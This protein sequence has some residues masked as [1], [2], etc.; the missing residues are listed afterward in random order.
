MSKPEDDPDTYDLATGPDVK[1]KGSV[2]FATTSAS[3]TSDP[4]ALQRELV[5][6][7]AQVADLLSILRRTN[8]PPSRPSV[9]GPGTGDPSPSLAIYSRPMFTTSK[10]KHLG[11]AASSLTSGSTPSTSA[12]SAGHADPDGPLARASI[13]PPRPYTSKMRFEDWWSQ[14]S[15]YLT[16]VAPANISDEA[17]ATHLIQALS[18]EVFSTLRGCGLLDS[19]L[20]STKEIYYKLVSRFGDKISPELYQQEFPQLKQGTKET[21]AEYC[22]RVRQIA[23]RAYPT[24]NENSREHRSAIVSQLLTGLKSPEIKR[25]LQAD[26]RLSLPEVP[27]PEVLYHSVRRYEDDELRATNKLVYFGSNAKVESKSTDKSEKTNTDSA[28]SNMTAGASNSQAGSSD[29]TSKKKGRKKGKQKAED[30][31]SDSNGSKNGSGPK[32]HCQLCN[33]P[34]HSASECRKFVCTKK[35]GNNGK[36]NASNASD[37]SKKKDFICYRCK[38][39]NHTAKNC[40]QTTDINGNQLEPASNA[41]SNAQ[42]GS[43]PFTS[44][45]GT[46]LNGNGGARSTESAAHYP[47]LW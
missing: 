27:D 46:N 22:D 33:I 10:L 26:L 23:H 9:S 45:A 3:G 4:D 38:R 15:A 13:K 30:K 20:S 7:R 47:K 11:T 8:L 21:A 14:F 35:D 17:A 2:H 12:P 41:Q 43:K 24:R 19:D 34:G 6:S 40:Y 1:P 31:T 37:G 5:E 39:P 44:Y 42:S 16:A 28:A 25:C 18:P 29:D 32:P 36:Q